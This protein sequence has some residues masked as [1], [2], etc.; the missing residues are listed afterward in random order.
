VYCRPTLKRIL[1]SGHSRLPVYR[2]SNRSD[3]IG[4]ILVKELLAVVGL[5][6]PGSGPVAVKALRMRDLP[7]LPVETAMTDLL[8]LFQVIGILVLC[9]YLLLLC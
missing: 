9:A 6:E 1:E 4:L 2:G 7:A 3:I 8:N 5:A